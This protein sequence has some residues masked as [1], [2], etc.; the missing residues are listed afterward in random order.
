MPVC[1]LCVW[2]AGSLCEKGA[3]PLFFTVWL[4]VSTLRNHPVAPVPP[5]LAACGSRGCGCPS[6]PRRFRAF[7]SAFKTVIYS[8]SCVWLCATPWTVA[9]QALLSVA[10]PRQE[11]Q[12]GLPFPP[13]GDLP[14]P[15]TE[16]TFPALAGGLFA[17][18]PPGKS[19]FQDALLLLQLLPKT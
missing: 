5:G 10:F 15:G 19:G 12:S 3:P 18:A 13:P 4:S 9:H 6:L 14:A 16:P 7:G 17:T 8:L 11:Y 1:G 2:T